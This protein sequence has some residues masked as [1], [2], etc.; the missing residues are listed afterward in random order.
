VVMAGLHRHFELTGGS[1]GEIFVVDLRH[2]IETAYGTLA[3]KPGEAV[4]LRVVR[5]R[6]DDVPRRAVD[7]A[8]TVLA[9]RADV[10]LRAEADQ[11]TLTDEDRAAALVLGGT[12]RHT[13]MIEAV[14]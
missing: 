13:L 9:D 14:R 4:G 5:D 11:K 2:R 1:L 3:A 10:H 12:P 8:L 7:R 6:L